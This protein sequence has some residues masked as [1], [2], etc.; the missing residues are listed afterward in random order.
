VVQWKGFEGNCLEKI[1]AI[2]RN[3]L[4]ELQETTK[5]NPLRMTMTQ[6]RFETDI[7]QI[8]V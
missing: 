5:E 1:D 7:S 2:F 6:P 3:L 8:Q 4:E